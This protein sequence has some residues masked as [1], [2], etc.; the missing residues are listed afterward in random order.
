MVDGAGH[1]REEL[2]VPVAVA[3]DERADLDPARLLGPRAE[4]GPALEVLAVG[5]AAEREE[6][7]PVEDHV[8]PGVLGA[9]HRV[10]DLGIVG[11]LG[12]ELDTDAHGT[13]HP[14]SLIGAT[15]GVPP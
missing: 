3:R 13:S 12:L 11:M 7:V 5:V 14:F 1:V 4:H 10:T 2:G 6:V 8:D 9:G 15:W